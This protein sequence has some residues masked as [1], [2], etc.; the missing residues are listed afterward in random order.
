VPGGPIAR[1]HRLE[2]EGLVP[3]LRLEPDP[4]SAVTIHGRATVAQH[5]NA[6]IDGRI[7]EDDE[8]D[9]AAHYAFEV[10][11]EHEAWP[12]QPLLRQA[13]VRTRPHPPAP[14]MTAVIP[15]RDNPPHDAGWRVDGHP[16]SA[17]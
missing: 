3:G 2:V 8:I 14:D 12:V 16:R 17:P 7:V 6:K 11:F 15:L 13:V 5:P 4:L 1:E 9:W 10:P